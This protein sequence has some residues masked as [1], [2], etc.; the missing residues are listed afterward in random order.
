MKNI[1]NN[2]VIE[3]RI[4]KLEKIIEGIASLERNVELSHCAR[5]LK[6]LEKGFEALVEELKR[7][8]VIQKGFQYKE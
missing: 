6:K 2:S 7:I 1:D 5:H 8:G 3:D 4:T